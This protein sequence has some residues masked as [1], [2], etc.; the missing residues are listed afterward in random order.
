MFNKL[1]RNVLKRSKKI[2]FST[3]YDSQSGQYINLQNNNKVYID[4]LS[5]IKYEIDAK[6]N[7]NLFIKYMKNII[8][9]S[10]KSIIFPSPEK[11]DITFNT[12]DKSLVYYLSNNISYLAKLYSTKSYSDIV[13]KVNNEDDINIVYKLL[14]YSNPIIEISITN[15]YN[16]YFNKSKELIKAAKML[17]LPIRGNLIIDLSF[18]QNLIELEYIFSYLA[19]EGVD[20]IFITSN[21]NDKNID[22]NVLR[23]VIEVNKAIILLFN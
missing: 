2:Y 13:C 17:K 21:N 5:L 15:D 20:V 10:P 8:R 7:E 12:I 4:D 23:E 1:S 16:N 18:E 11:K 3:I 22:L 14:K 6:Y 9:L 19:D